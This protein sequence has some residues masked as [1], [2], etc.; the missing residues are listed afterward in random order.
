[1]LTRSPNPCPRPGLA[2]TQVVHESEGV[3]DPR[4]ELHAVENLSAFTKAC[5]YI[6]VPSECLFNAADLDF[7]GAS[8]RTN[9]A[10]CVL[11]L[12]RLVEREEGGMGGSRVGTPLA[13]AASSPW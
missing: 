1:M 8:E 12:K 13:I 10:D 4:R 2:A 9:V 11:A 5:R 6:G 7:E 3:D